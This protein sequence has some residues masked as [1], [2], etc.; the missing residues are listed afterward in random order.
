MFWR[1]PDAAVHA[2]R[3]GVPWMK[4]IKLTV[5]CVL[6]VAAAAFTAVRFGGLEVRRLQ[7]EVERLDQERRQLYEYAQRLSAGRRAA[8][9]DVL[10]QRVNERGETVSTLLWQEIGRDGV[11]GSPVALEVIGKQVYFEAL[12]IK[13]K[14]QFVGEGDPLR[15]ASVAL[16]RRIFGE[17]Q[18]PESVPDLD[19]T[20]Q[21]P[22]RGDAE[23]LA[24]YQELWRRFWEIVDHPELAERYGVR[25]AQCEAPA[26]RIS[27]GQTWEM[28]LDSDGGLNLRSMNGEGCVISA[29]RAQSRAAESP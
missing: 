8:Q 29:P 28:I 14:P 24:F 25:I 16:F 26:V 10:R 7:A 15:G 22:L 3:K 11:L 2:E 6:I 13:F 5:S 21:P 4:W 1:V 19:R 27:A 12:V 23:A 9:L 17:G 20:A 18:A